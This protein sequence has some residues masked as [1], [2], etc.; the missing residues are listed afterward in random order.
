VMRLHQ[1]RKVDL[2][3]GKRLGK[4]ERLVVW[5]R[6]KRT[7]HWSPEEWNA[8]PETLTLRIVRVQINVPGFRVQSFWL[9]TTLLDPVR[10]DKQALAELYLR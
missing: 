6:P 1:A 5:K 7:A 3:K 4:N 8:L 9:V 10:Y 2:R